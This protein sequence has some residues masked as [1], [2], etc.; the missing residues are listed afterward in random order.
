ML[1]SARWPARH[2]TGVRNR[3]V[4]QNASRKLETADVVP[5]ELASIGDRGEKRVPR[6]DRASVIVTGT[7]GEVIFVARKTADQIASPDGGIIGHAEIGVAV[8]QVDLAAFEDMPDLEVHYTGNSIRPISG[9]GAI[10]QDL[11]VLD[12][13]K[14]QRIDVLE[15]KGAPAIDHRKRVPASERAQI[16]LRSACPARAVVFV[17]SVLPT[18]DGTCRRP[19]AGVFAP[20]VINSSR[21]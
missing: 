14:R 17:V 16:D 5:P 18:H 1:K 12:E 9:R 8:K 20:N 4:S 10:F 2:G 11:D 21:E 3:N 7:G 13:S 19:S 6:E 15:T